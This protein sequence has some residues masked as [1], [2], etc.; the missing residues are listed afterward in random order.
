MTVTDS[1]CLSQ[2]IFVCQSKYVCVTDSLCLSKTVYFC[3]RQSVFIA[4]RFCLSQKDFVSQSLSLLKTLFDQPW[5]DLYF[6]NMLF[7]S[8]FFREIAVCLG[9]QSHQSTLCGP[10]SLTH[11]MSPSKR[12]SRI[13][14]YK[15]ETSRTSKTSRT[16]KTVKPSTA[17]YYQVQLGTTMYNQVQSCTNGCNW[18]QTSTTGCNWLKL[19]RTG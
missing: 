1:C 12:M 16:G 9:F 19:F 5:P 10:L 11:F 15:G 14:E 4:N 3:R 8:R 18:V 13:E 2:K 6:F 17:R 7:S